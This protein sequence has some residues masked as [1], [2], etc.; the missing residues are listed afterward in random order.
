MKYLFSA[1]TWLIAVASTAQQQASLVVEIVNNGGLVQ[2][3]TYRLWAKLSESDLTLH[4]VWGDEANPLSITSTSPFYQH[5]LGTQTSSGMNEALIALYP[6]LT[7]DSYIT[8]GYERSSGNA[9]WDIGI[10]FNSFNS[11]GALSATNGAWFLLPTDEKCSPQSAGLVLLGQFTSSGI[12]SGTINLQGWDGSRE[13]WQVRAASFT[14]ANAKVFGCTDPL[15]ENF[16][17]DATFDNGSCRGELQ[18]AAGIALSG[19]MEKGGWEVF[20]NPVRESLIHLQFDEGMSIHDRNARIDI[21][22]LSGR[23]VGSH[24]ISSGGMLAGNRMTIRQEL[25]P[26]TYKVVLVRGELTDSRTI[27]VQR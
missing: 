7:Y 26:G 12:V 4:S 15:S 9:L 6:E 22:D 18:V 16:N 27:I 20:P 10:D 25:V 2:G 19:A 13:P 14:T 17:P 21:F 1:F 11:G 3:S 8:L 23:K 5:P 24:G